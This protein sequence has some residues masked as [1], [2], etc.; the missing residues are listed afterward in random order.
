MCNFSAVPATSSELLPPSC[1]LGFLTRKAGPSRAPSPVEL[2]RAAT[3]VMHV[4]CSSQHPAN[5]VHHPSSP[6]GHPRVKP[7]TTLAPAGF[8]AKL[9]SGVTRKTSLWLPELPSWSGNVTSGTQLELEPASPDRQ[10][11]RPPTAFTQIPPKAG[12]KY[13]LA[14]ADIF[15]SWVEAFCSRT[16]KATEMCKCLLKEI[17][18]RSG[19]AQVPSEQQWGLFHC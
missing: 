17:I 10:A 2:F 8:S 12:C 1:R 6:P 4:A 7:P 11:L 18:P 9:T 16:E 19:A 14:S 15:T 13:L 5:G 3:E